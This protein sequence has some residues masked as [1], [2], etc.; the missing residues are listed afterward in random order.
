MTGAKT[1]SFWVRTVLLLCV[2]MQAVALM[3][4]HHHGDA[5]AVCL[6][7][8]HMYDTGAC[9]DV[10]TGAD[11]H[12]SQPYVVCHLHGITVVQ[13]QEREDVAAEWTVGHDHDCGC[14]ACARDAAFAAM[15]H[16]AS[17][18]VP[19]GEVCC[20]DAASRIRDY[21]TAALPC[22]APDFMC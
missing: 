15:E 2:L 12:S 9:G 22:R 7:Y 1:N 13:P 10:C 4:H 11:S 6:N 3:P 16:L 19:C 14:A 18:A 5:A 8:F 17:R 21:F 20:D